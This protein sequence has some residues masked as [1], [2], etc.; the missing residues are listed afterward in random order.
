MTLIDLSVLVGAAGAWSV[1]CRD[2]FVL[3]T[4]RRTASVER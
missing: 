1:G 3:A 4:T 2:P